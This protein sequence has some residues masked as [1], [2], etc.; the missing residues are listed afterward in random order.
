MSKS[1]LKDTEAVNPAEGWMEVGLLGKGQRAPPPV[2]MHGERCEIPS[3]LDMGHWTVV[4]DGAANAF[5]AFFT[6][7][8]VGLLST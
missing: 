6:P 5:P 8:I 7:R 4:W 3:C 1:G 2:K